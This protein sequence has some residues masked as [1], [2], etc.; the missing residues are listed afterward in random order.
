MNL[1]I[2]IST[3]DFQI[4]CNVLSLSFS[5]RESGKYS[6]GLSD[7]SFFGCIIILSVILSIQHYGEI[8]I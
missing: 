8:S 1:I 5:G 3:G 4:C 2:V 7:F 6:L